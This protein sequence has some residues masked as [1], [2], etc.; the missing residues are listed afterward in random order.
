MVKPERTLVILKPDS[1]QR[2]II[3]QIISRFEQR[4]FRIAG[5]KMVH[6][7]EQQLGL[8]YADDKEWKLSVGKKTRESML[9]KGVQMSETDEQIGDR[10]RSWNMTGLSMPVL[11][12]V[13]EGYHAIE[14]VRAMIGGTEPRSSAPGTIRGDFACDSYAKADVDKR[15]VRNLVHAS[16][17]IKEA[18]T[19][20]AVWFKKE[21]LF[22]Y[23]RHDWAIM[24]G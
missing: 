18:E 22:D 3:G 2:A 6:P 24:H 21:E 7:T 12:V 9:S 8:H 5:M 17:S 23:P 14:T 4:G 10:I 13:L 19:E 16:S 15:V 11:A 1:V 20:V